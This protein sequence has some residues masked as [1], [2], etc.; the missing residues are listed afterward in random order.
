VAEVS[1][2]RKAI[3]QG[4]AQFFGGE[5]S[6]PDDWYRSSPLAD[7]G[8]SGV[9]AYY[10]GR[11][12]DHEYFGDLNGARTGAIMCVHLNDDTEKR[13][14]IGGILD[15]PFNVSLFLFFLTLT[16]SQADAQA[17]RD[18]LLEAARALIRADPTLGMGVNSDAPAKVTQAGEGEA[19]IATSTPVP[20]FEPPA[21]TMQNAVIS[22]T[23][24]TYPAG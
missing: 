17:D 14:A 6:D 7:L 11:F 12:K 8:L 24:N 22:F 1:V 18:D 2:T 15:A 13:L 10:Q 4:I 23:A 3:R 16:P 5:V 9:K 19:G 20:Y 21:K